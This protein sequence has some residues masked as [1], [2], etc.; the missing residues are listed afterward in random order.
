MSKTLRTAVLAVA[1]LSVGVLGTRA[2][3]SGTCARPSS[4]LSNWAALNHFCPDEPALASEVNSNF[5][6]VVGWVEAKTG[7]VGSPLTLPGTP[8]NSANIADGTITS[9]DLANDSVTSLDLAPGSVGT[10][11][12]ADGGVTAAKLAGRAAVYLIPTPCPN[13]GLLTTATTCPEPFGATPCGGSCTIGQSRWTV[14]DGSCGPCSG[15][16]TVISCPKPTVLLGYV[17]PP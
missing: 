13:A 2:L 15:G 17:V 11:E 16:P 8:V 12:L 6:T 5:A 1:F 3:A 4:F 7:P 9:A 10:W 14:C